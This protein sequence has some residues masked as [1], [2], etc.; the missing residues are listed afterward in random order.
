MLIVNGEF[1]AESTYENLSHENTRFV[2]DII[3]YFLFSWEYRSCGN[4]GNVSM[5]E[6]TF[7]SYTFRPQISNLVSGSTIIF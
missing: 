6:K 2:D 1:G 7:I 3:N 5:F 4:N